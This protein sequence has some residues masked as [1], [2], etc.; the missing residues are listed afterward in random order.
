MA[1]HSGNCAGGI[2]YSRG[3]GRR[4][5]GCLGDDDTQSFQVVIHLPTG[6]IYVQ[7]PDAG[8]ASVD[9]LA[10]LAADNPTTLPLGFAYGARR[11]SRCVLMADS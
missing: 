1:A 4:F 11:S 2:W 3:H 10:A 7:E 9:A 8:A 6:G 5:S